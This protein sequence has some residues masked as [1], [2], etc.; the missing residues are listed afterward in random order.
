[1]SKELDEHSLT[2]LSAQSDGVISDAS[3]YYRNE[4]QSISALQ[5][6]YAWAESIHDDAED[7]MDALV[8]YDL[9]GAKGYYV[10]ASI[11][12]AMLV[13]MYNMQPLRRR[14]LDQ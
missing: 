14:Q 10:L 3:E 11:R 9:E 8:A 12:Q 7:V 1:V 5:Q 6:S 2:A 4:T 13:E